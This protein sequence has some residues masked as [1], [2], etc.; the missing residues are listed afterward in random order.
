MILMVLW[1]ELWSDSLIML[2][3][4]CTNWIDFFKKIIP[5]ENI[6][7]CQRWNNICIPG[8]LAW[9]IQMLLKYILGRY[10]ICVLGEK[11]Q[12]NNI[13]KEGNLAYAE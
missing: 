3:Y 13:Y 6:C 11:S 8:S 10:L 4:I 12:L 7:P 5:I 2:F 1:Q 9:F